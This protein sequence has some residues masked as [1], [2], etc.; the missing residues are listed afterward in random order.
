MSVIALLTDFGHQ[1]PFVGVMKGVIAGL[2]PKASVIDLCHEVPPQDVRSGALFLRQSVPY[3]PDGTIF[4]AVVDP[5][6]GSERRPCLAR[7]RRH[8]FIGPDNGLFSWLPERVLEWRE[9]RVPDGASATFHGRDVFAPAAARFAAAGGPV[10]EIVGKRFKDPMTLPWPKDVV[11]AF[12]RF[13]NA[14]TTVESGPRAVRYKNKVYAVKRTYADVKEGQELAY[15]GSSGLIELAVRNGNFA[16][17]RGAK[18]GDA[19]QP[20]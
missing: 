14:V 13:G 7:T 10:P 11:L 1:D 12:D 9:L 17:K 19:V 6:V 16:A 18:R 2:A 15:V 8:L 20:A 3:F 5:G 4:C